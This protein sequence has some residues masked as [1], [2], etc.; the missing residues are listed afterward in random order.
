MQKI[1]V[2]VRE[3]WRAIST[4]MRGIIILLKEIRFI[5][6]GDED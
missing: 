1:W 2:E 6:I 3:R 4:Y 5:L